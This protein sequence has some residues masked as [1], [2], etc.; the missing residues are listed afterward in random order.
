[1]SKN[2]LWWVSWHP[3]TMKEPHAV[4]H[5]DESQIRYFDDKDDA[6]AFKRE[7]TKVMPDGRWILADSD[8]VWKHQYPDVEV[9]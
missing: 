7:I 1:M 4:H 8:W 9:F 6:D 2:L 3:T 5:Y